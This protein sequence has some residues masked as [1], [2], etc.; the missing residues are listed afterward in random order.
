MPAITGAQSE[1]GCNPIQE[2]EIC[3]QEF[4]LS[5]T[6]VDAGNRTEITLKVQN[7]GSQIG[8][9]VV[10]LGIQQPEGSY[11][12]RR[13]EEIHN[14]ESGDIQTVS[15]PLQVSEPVGVHELNVML[16]DQSEQHLYDASGY[17]QKITV[18]RSEN[19]F[20]L[21]G[22]FKNLGRIAQSAIAIIS[23]GAIVL[24]RK[25]WAK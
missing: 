23:L 17:Y 1:T 6:T 5:K 18:E 7:A 10:L 2:T 19:S 24:G 25:R 4:S 3:I 12:H 13:V 8:D 21:V 14:L 22:W 9:A 16:F 15:V 11:D 20:D